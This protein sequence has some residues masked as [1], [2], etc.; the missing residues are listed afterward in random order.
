[1]YERE[2]A[3]EE[4][5]AADPLSIGRVLTQRKN[6][7]SRHQ[8]AQSRHLAQFANTAKKADEAAAAGTS[9]ACNIHRLLDEV[10]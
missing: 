4:A 9:Y 2:C 6:L 8:A 5:N 10:D 1:L 7:Y 3:S